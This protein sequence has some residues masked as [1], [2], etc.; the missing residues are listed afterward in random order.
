MDFTVLQLQFSTEKYILNVILC[1]EGNGKHLVEA[2]KTH[3]LARLIFHGLAVSERYYGDQ[4]IQCNI[5]SVGRLTLSCGAKIMLDR[6]K[7]IG[8][9]EVLVGDTDFHPNLLKPEYTLLVF[10]LHSDCKITYNM[11]NLGVI[12][13]YS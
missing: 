2:R 12:F 8:D 10:S 13:N 9:D 5:A 7:R 4:S 3:I 11:H 1:S 6:I